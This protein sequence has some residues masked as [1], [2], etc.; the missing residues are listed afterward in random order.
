MWEY[1]SVQCCPLSQTVLLCFKVS[2]LCLLVLK[3]NVKMQMSMEKWWNDTNRGSWNI[4][5]KTCPIATL[6]AVNL[7]WTGPGLHPVMCGDTPLTTCLSCGSNVSSKGVQP[8]VYGH[9]CKLYCKKL[10]INL[11]SSLYHQSFFCLAGELA[12]NNGCDS[13]PRKGWMPLI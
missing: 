10:C 13:L 2:T 12:H 5:S 4:W 11:S 1:I 9:I 7:I 6:S 8:A 3:S